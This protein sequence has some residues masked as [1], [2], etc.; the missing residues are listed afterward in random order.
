MTTKSTDRTSATAQAGLERWEIDPTGS[1]LEFTLRHLIIQELRG[2]FHRWGGTVHIDR[3]QPLRSRVEVWIELASIDTGSTERDDHL[4]SDEFLDVARYPRARFTGTA[5]AVG[6]DGILLRGRLDLHGVNQAIEVEV[7]PG[8]TG[9]DANGVARAQYG[10]RGAINRQIYALHWNQDLDVG[11][12][13][14][15]DRIELRANVET[16]RVP[17]ASHT[18]RPQTRP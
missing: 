4:R 13:V 15:G 1:S 11:G 10:A 12:V 8:E 18:T 17:A 7:I 16:L 14:V 3:E 6:T 2:V 5:V 9:H